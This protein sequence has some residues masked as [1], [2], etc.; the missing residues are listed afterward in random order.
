MSA[1]NLNIETRRVVRRHE[2]AQ[3]QISRLTHENRL[4]KEQIQEN[5]VKV[6]G[7][8]SHYQN[9]IECQAQLVSS[10]KSELRDMERKR[11]GKGKSVSDKSTRIDEGDFK[12]RESDLQQL[13]LALKNEVGSLKKKQIIERNDF[14][15]RSL[16]NQAEVKKSFDE[17]V[18]VIKRLASEAVCNEV[19]E[20]I[21][22]TLCDNERL[23]REFRALLIEMEI[24]QKNLDNKCTE[25]NKTKRELEFTR[26]REEILLA[27]SVNGLFKGNDGRKKIEEIP[28]QKPVS[29]DNSNKDDTSRMDFKLEKYFARCIE[30]S[31]R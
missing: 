29:V 27:K 11:G 31:I 22:A 3:N 21:E 8:I 19:R 9:E 25:L 6:L 1:I 28:C 16:I 7:L 18:D 5:E 20:A 10:L 17:D 12:S 4:L 30:E 15:R 24:T 14:E 2:S 13:V 26:H 23:A